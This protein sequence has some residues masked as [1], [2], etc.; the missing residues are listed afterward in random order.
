MHTSAAA[1][2]IN[3]PRNKIKAKTGGALGQAAKR[4]KEAGPRPQAYC[5]RSLADN[6]F[7]CCQACKRAIICR[8]PGRAKAFQKT[9]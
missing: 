8:Y 2:V 3:E 5:L 4:E 6:Q 9:S 7:A 1:Y